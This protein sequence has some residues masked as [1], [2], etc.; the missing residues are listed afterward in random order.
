MEA[1]KKRKTEVEKTAAAE[2]EHKKRK[3]TIDPK[4]LERKQKEE[5]EFMR[6]LDL[7]TAADGLSL[8]ASPQKG[9]AAIV[10]KEK[11]NTGQEGKKSE[12]L[13]KA[14]SQAGLQSKP[15]VMY[16]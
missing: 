14:K 2:H 9:R 1:K 10:P 12:E 13:N 11:E 7:I 5:E 3:E 15:M 8:V 4:E 16:I 6:H